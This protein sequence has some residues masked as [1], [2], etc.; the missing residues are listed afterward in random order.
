[1]ISRS[2]LVSA[3]CLAGPAGA[4]CRVAEAE[5]C[6]L[7]LQG[8]GAPAASESCSTEIWTG[9]LALSLPEGFADHDEDG[10]FESVVEVAVGPEKGCGCVIFRLEFAAPP[11]GNVLDIGDSP[12]NDGA[13]GDAGSTQHDAEMTLVGDV[14]RL[15]GS[16][17]EGPLLGA[18]ELFG[19]S[20]LELDGRTATLELCDQA[21]RFDFG[22]Q[23]FYSSRNAR[24]F[25]A[26][27]PAGSAK[28]AEVPDTPQ[29]PDDR[30]YAGFNRVIHRRT[31]RPVL[32]RFGSGI[33]RVEIAIT[34]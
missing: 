22:Q 1:M 4:Q 25:V 17:Q 20:D 5:P 10:W 27:R 29:E 31:S 33:A 21:L 26:I 30:V 8:E 13:G 3:L 32:D 34:P 14:F 2:I 9:H 11:V 23:G 12:T 28:V 19:L 18:E 16:D 24:D 15:Y 6:V 7:T